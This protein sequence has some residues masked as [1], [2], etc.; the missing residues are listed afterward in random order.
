MKY[1]VYELADPSTGDAFYVG[2]GTGK[3]IHAHEKEAAE[4]VSS[5]KCN[6]I[7]KI[8][9]SGQKVIK[10]KIGLFTDEK[11]AYEF[12]AL[13]IAE[14]NERLTNI[15]GV[16]RNAQKIAKDVHL[17]DEYM[18]CIAIGLKLTS[19]KMD[20][21]RLPFA[22]ALARAF[23]EQFDEFFDNARKRLSDE[24]IIEGVRRFGVD[25]K[26]CPQGSS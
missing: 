14:Y 19:G 8:L 10:R 16:V 22:G 9:N 6:K 18:N 5:Y 15:V 4:G 26:L 7:R 1:Y 23:I 20:V 25:L 2:K 24:Q 17:S 3:R 13:K 11:R 21:P 12:E